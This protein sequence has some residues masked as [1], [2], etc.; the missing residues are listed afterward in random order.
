MTYF[1]IILPY[2]IMMYSASETLKSLQV[3]LSYNML[4]LNC[5]KY[6]NS[7]SYGLML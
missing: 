7:K 2:K 6:Q 4:L 1:M 3:E 5:L